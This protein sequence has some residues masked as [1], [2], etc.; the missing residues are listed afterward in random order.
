MRS[1]RTNDPIEVYLS[2]VYPI[3]VYP[4]EDGYVAEIE[5]LP[6]CITQGDTIE[7]VMARIDDARRGWIEVAYEDGQEIPLP[8][9]E[10]QYSGRFVARVPKSLHR[11]L[12][13][14]A[15]RQGV[16]LNQYVVYLLSQNI[17][18]D[19][20]R[21][22]ARQVTEGQWEV[23][24]S[25]FKTACTRFENGLSTARG[26]TRLVDVFMPAGAEKRLFERAKE[27]V[28]A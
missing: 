6:G 1:T 19:E 13:E 8:H 7:E 16:S 3:V 26:M 10:E 20:M 12:A 22:V 9:I 4:E 15:A 17:A 25:S 14:M 11:Q 18:I 21:D 28:A 5:E 27:P 2:K 23:V 24:A